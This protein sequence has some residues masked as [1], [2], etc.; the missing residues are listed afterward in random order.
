MKRLVCILA[1]ACMALSHAQET[2]PASGPRTWNFE[3]DGTMESDSGSLSFKKGGR[4]DA[5]FVR[6][7]DSKTV[8]LKPVGSML[9]YSLSISNFCREDQRLLREAPELLR[10]GNQI[11][12]LA[13]G[14]P[15]YENKALET[16]VLSN[17]SAFYEWDKMKSGF[18]ATLTVETLEPRIKFIIRNC[19]YDPSQWKTNKELS[20]TSDAIFTRICPATNITLKAWCIS[21]GSV[22]SSGSKVQSIEKVYDCEVWNPGE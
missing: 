19:R 7:V 2:P 15:S 18:T 22:R 14:L 21:N 5:E 9:I 1:M 12:G 17:P 16:L 20:R 6:L 11:V 13:P 4:M 8:L 10:K 3:R